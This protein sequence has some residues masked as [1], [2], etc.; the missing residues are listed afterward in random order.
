MKGEERSEFLN[1]SETAQDL[2]FHTGCTIANELTNSD[3]RTQTLSRSVLPFA[4]AHFKINYVLNTHFNEYDV[5]KDSDKKCKIRTVCAYSMLKSMSHAEITLSS[6][7]LEHRSRKIQVK[8]RTTRHISPESSL[9]GFSQIFK[10]L[11]YQCKLGQCTIFFIFPVL[12][13]LGITL[14]QVKIIGAVK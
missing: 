2:S 1:V 8:M 14:G 12:R 5:F 3:L 11:V 9:K 10:H 4:I 7:L 13:I 6:V